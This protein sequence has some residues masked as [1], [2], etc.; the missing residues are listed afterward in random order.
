MFFFSRSSTVSTMDWWWTSLFIKSYWTIRKW[1]LSI[2]WKLSNLSKPKW[3]MSTVYYW[4][5]YKNT[6]YSRG[7]I[8]INKENKTCFFPFLSLSRNY[9]YVTLI[10]GWKIFSRISCWSIKKTIRFSMILSLWNALCQLTF[11]GLYIKLFAIHTL[12]DQ[13]QKKYFTEILKSWTM[14]SF[15]ALH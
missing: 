15:H 11:A 5:N 13:L 2:T 9:I 8:H 6:L 10:L 1:K 14:W 4:S 7:K 12:I 3:K